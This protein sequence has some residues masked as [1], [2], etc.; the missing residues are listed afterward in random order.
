MED[1]RGPAYVEGLSPISFF[2]IFPNFSFVSGRYIFRLRIIVVIFT[3]DSLYTRY[4]YQRFYFS[5]M[6]IVNTVSAA[7]AEAAA[8]AP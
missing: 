8:Q 1:G 5:V 7:T 6:R 4:G 3:G 2:V